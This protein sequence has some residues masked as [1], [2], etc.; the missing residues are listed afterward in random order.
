MNKSDGSPKYPILN[1]VVK[2]LLIIPHGNADVERDFSQNRRLLHDR[3]W[4]TVES[5]NGIRH[6][7]SYGKRCGSDPS[8]FSITPEVAM[9]VRN[10]KK[11]YSERIASEEE[12]STK[13]QHKADEAGRSSNEEADLQKEV[14]IAKMLTN[15]QL[16]ISHGLKS[17]DLADIES[18]NSLL[19]EGK[20][21]LALEKMTERKKKRKLP[22]RT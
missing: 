2:A 1:K 5:I 15:A 20:S 8:R 11:L 21:R 19:A 6:N 4:L 16:L 9:V 3:A 14:E 10:S 13:Q 7:V 12:Q 18:G 22:A 17:K